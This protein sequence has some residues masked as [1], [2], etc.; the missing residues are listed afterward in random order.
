MVCIMFFFLWFL[1]GLFSAW[2]FSG[3]VNMILC[4][5]LVFAGFARKTLEIHWFSLIFLGWRSQTI[6]KPYQN[7]TKTIPKPYQSHKNYGFGMVWVWFW[8]GF[9]LRAHENLGKS[10]DVAAFARKTIENHWFVQSFCYQ[11]QRISWVFAGFARKTL[12]FH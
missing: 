3:P 7:H 11:N 2:T 5:T 4:C 8:Y 6:V 9:Q 1:Y 12:E 10:M